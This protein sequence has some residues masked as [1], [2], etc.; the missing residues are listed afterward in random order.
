MSKNVNG[1]PSSL[2]QIAT[3]TE[4]TFLD[5]IRSRRFAIL[6]SIVLSVTAI[7][8][9]VISYN[10]LSIFFVW[11]AFAPIVTM[12]AGVFFGADAIS[13]EFQNKTGY[14]SIPN[15]IKR[16]TVYFG[17]WLAAFAASSI[18]LAIFAVITVCIG[19][20]HGGVP[21]E[22]GLSLLFAW[23]FL[24][25]VVG[26]TFFFSSLFKN[27]TYSIFIAAML[28]L[29]VFTAITNLTGMIPLEPWFILNY[30]AQIVG[31]ILAAPY[32]QHVTPNVNMGKGI[33]ETTYAATVPEGL[34][35]IAVYFAVTTLLGLML[36]EKHEFT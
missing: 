22:F 7:L 6:L 5:Y 36:F 25:A 11:G 14:F 1:I 28:L 3:V 20:V 33:I 9:A 27:T 24:A 23:F 17:K 31:S 18:M 4:Y 16:S 2:S 8:A 35:I 26:F 32:P 13:G 10:V 15:P 29:V 21:S 19:V 30:A 12:L 34:V